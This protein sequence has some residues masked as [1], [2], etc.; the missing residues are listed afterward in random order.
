[1]IPCFQAILIALV[2]LS[3]LAQSPPKRKKVKDFGSSLKRW[4]WNPQKNAAEF[5]SA[6]K[7][8]VL[9]EGDVIRTDI[10]LVSSDLLVLDQKGNSVTGLTAA[11]FVIA[12]NNVPQTVGHFFNGDNVDVPRTIVLI[13]DYSGSQLAY[14]YNSIKAAKVLVDKLGPKDLMAIVTDDVELLVD[15][16][17]DKQQLKDRLDTMLQRIKPKPFPVESADFFPRLGRSRQYSALMA[18]LKEM[19]HEEDMRRIVIFQTDG[20]EAYFMRNPVVGVTG[21]RLYG[22]ALA[23]AQRRLPFYM[24][25]SVE[26]EFSL[27]D[28]YR[29]VE[30]KHVTVYSVIP[31]IKLWGLSFEEQLQKISFDRAIGTPGWM[32]HLSPRE[33]ADLLERMQRRKSEKVDKD[34]QKLVLET[35]AKLQ[36]VSASV[37]TVSGGWAD[38]LEIPDQADAIYSRIFSDINQRYIVGYYPTNKERD[39]KRRKIEIKVKGHPEYQV[40]GRFSYF[41]P[42][43]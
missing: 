39:G 4:K 22:E 29:T 38:F 7:E 11:D 17:S 33:M 10:S 32:G 8:Q 15:F 18:T 1:M 41:A 23:K 35:I 40:Y 6:K 2:T 20:D 13:I 36:A 14:L 3:L 42:E 31:G 12:E 43:P 27:E 19:F 9:D 5:R 24:N 16:T 37:A 34:V 26:L 30:Q 28:L 21:P 25:D